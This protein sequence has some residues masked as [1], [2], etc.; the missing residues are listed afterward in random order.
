MMKR[1]LTKKNFSF[2]CDS[3]H[4]LNTS[5]LKIIFMKYRS[6]KKCYICL[7][8]K[9]KRI[10][11]ILCLMYDSS[12][13]QNENV[14]S[15]FFYGKNM[16]AQNSH[17]SF[18]LRANST[19]LKLKVN[20]I[21]DT[22]TS[23]FLEFQLYSCRKKTVKKEKQTL[24]TIKY[25]FWKTGVRFLLWYIIIFLWFHEQ[26]PVLRVNGLFKTVLRSGVSAQTRYRNILQAI[27]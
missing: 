20:N 13:A 19:V 9:A 24:R 8:E 1:G 16:T 15:Q 4:F 23:L 10:S 18:R 3:K 6:T 11:I 25:I 12:F 5:F 14:M 2:H 26:E 7:E 17:N 27:T 22:M 21:S